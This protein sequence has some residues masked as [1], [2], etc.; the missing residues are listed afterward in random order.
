MWFIMTKD[1][2]SLLSQ[3]LDETP[4]LRTKHDQDPHV[5]ER[6]ASSIG[7]RREDVSS[8]LEIHGGGSMGGGVL[9]V[10]DQRVGLQGNTVWRPGRRACQK[11]RDRQLTLWTEACDA[12]AAG[13]PRGPDTS[14]GAG[15][16]VR[17]SSHSFSPGEVRRWKRDWS[18]RRGGEVLGEAQ[19]ARTDGFPWRKLA[20]LEGPTQESRL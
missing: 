4:E 20:G 12:L 13:S 3:N 15:A 17:Q 11:R 5:L 10:G 7:G 6:N 18:I 19:K 2:F 14:Q 8:D 16:N 1:A 9:E